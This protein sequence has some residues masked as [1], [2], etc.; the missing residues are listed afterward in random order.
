[1]IV[2]DD[3]VE[4]LTPLAYELLDQNRRLSKSARQM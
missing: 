2:A 3:L 1:M 4:F